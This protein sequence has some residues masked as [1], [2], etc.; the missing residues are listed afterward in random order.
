MA[1]ASAGPSRTDVRGCAFPSPFRFVHPIVRRALER[2]L[3][4]Q[5]QSALHREAAALLAESGAPTGA[6]AA[7]LVATEPASSTWIVERRR[8][9]AREARARGAPDVAVTY[10]EYERRTARQITVIALH[11]PAPEA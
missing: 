9:A 10:A 11:P 6:V 7:H 1:V 4:A 3:G 5:A 2:N 8:E